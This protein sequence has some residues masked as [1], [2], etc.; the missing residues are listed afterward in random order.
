MNT[1]TV[2]KLYKICEG[3]NNRFPCNSDPF[4]ILARLTEECGELASE[5]HHF[6]GIGRKR[7]KY[8]E[9]DKVKLAKEI[10]DVMT[11]VLS[12]ALHYGVEEE[13]ALSIDKHYCMV[14]DE[15]LITADE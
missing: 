8:G 15:G 14:I 10:Q 2:Q 1:E 7:E 9:A 13:L 12:F 4:R 6:E 3:L 11:S 5:V